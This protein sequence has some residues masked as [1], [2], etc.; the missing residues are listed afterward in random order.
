MVNV[1]SDEIKTMFVGDMGIK[2][3]AIGEEK[4]YERVSSYVYIQLISD[5]GEAE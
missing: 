3:A 4:I 5:D 2:T 1:G